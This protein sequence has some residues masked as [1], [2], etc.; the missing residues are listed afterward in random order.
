MPKLDICLFSNCLVNSPKLFDL[1]S[2]SNEIN[3]VLILGDRNS[4]ENLPKNFIINEDI[5]SFYNSADLNRIINKCKSEFVLFV[6][7][8]SKID[9][10]ENSLKRLL[11][12]AESS[13]SVF[14]YS[15]Y[16]EKKGEQFSVHKLID[17]QVGSIRDDFDFGKVILFKK[18]ELKNNI[19]VNN[20][21]YA[22]FY[23]LRLRI[24]EQY[25]LTRI[26]EALYTH[27]ETDLRKSGEKQFD[28]VDP[29]NRDVQLEMEKAATEHL[30]RIDALIS[31]GKEI[32]VF[33]DEFPVTAS[34]IIPVKN[35]VKTISNAIDSALSQK[36][37]FQFNIIVVDN[38]ST[39]GTREILENYQSQNDKVILVVPGSK[40][41]N[42]GGCWNLAIDHRACGKFA[43][44]LDSDDMYSSNDTL[45]QI[46]DTFEK[47]KCAMVIGSYT[48]T[49]FNLEVLPPGLIDHKEWTPENGMNNALRING[50]G[51][52]RSFYTPIIRSIGFPNTSYG[53]DYAV[54]LAISREYKVGRIYN[55]IY[56]CRRWEGNTDSDLSIEKVNE[57]NFYKDKIRTFE[58]LARQK[59][60]KK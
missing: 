25:S 33:S 20:Y 51:A 8:E 45:A 42:I 53:E 56:N 55:S 59:M 46:V 43:V 2:N 50:L 5:S 11:R 17:Y 36:T 31:P 41:L 18:N 22:A 27:E 21:R 60:N 35:R 29:K 23:D 28:Y 1:L 38:H 37:R 19:V 14:L 47:E 3:Q 12:I 30:Q 4:H 54:A 49:D 40:N 24:A 15:D 9:L 34:V 13:N 10:S 16:I 52:P 6:L 32:S 44:Q 57:N 48:M 58:I 7:S 39:D 26:P